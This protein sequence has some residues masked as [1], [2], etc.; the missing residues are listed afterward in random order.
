MSTANPVFWA[1]RRRATA[2]QSSPVRTGV[3]GSRQ[4]SG[5]FTSST[6]PPS[7]STATAAVPAH[8]SWPLNA[9]RSSTTSVPSRNNTSVRSR[10][11]SGSSR[12]VFEKPS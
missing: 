8:V 9:P 5:P 3:A 1:T 7:F 4:P 6:S 10:H 2:A 11:C 12:H